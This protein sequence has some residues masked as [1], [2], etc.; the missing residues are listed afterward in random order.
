MRKLAITNGPMASAMGLVLLLA[1]SPAHAQPS[2]T[3]TS[4][5]PLPVPR[6]EVTAVSDGSSI[7]LVGGMA[8]DTTADVR[9]IFRY[10]PTSDSWL[11]AARLDSAVHHTGAVI[12]DGR[13]YVI[14]GYEGRRDQPS[15]R[16]RAIDPATG[17][18]HEAAP[19][20]T[21]RGALTAVVLDGR[22]HA[23]GGTTDT[24][25]AGNAATI[26]THE[27]YDPA[28]DRWTE[29]A[30]MQVPRNHHAAAVLD[31]KIY[32]FGGRDGSTF[33]LDDAE[34]YDPATDR[35]TTLAPLPTGRS[36]IAAATVGDRIVVFGGEVFGREKKTFDEAEAFQPATGSWAAL[37]RMP[38]A[39]HGI[40]VAAIGNS[41]H[42]IAGG[43][44]PGLTVSDAHEVLTLGR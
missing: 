25:G 20:P 24:L 28:T 10:D 41:I 2:A 3:W 38:T 18:L 23:L 12:L 37:P 40:G 17:E 32:V 26:A 36:G 14:G 33:L 7:F 9:T 6:T 16:L 1:A 5:A 42:V 22:I 35:W 34:V 31:G 13:L 39:R 30:P 21:S 19:M 8:R 11:A 44:Q 4:K 43:P 29:A 15:P 27:V